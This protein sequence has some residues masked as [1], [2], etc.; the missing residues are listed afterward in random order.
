MIDTHDKETEL[1]QPMTQLAQ[2]PFDRSRIELL[3]QENKLIEALTLLRQC[4][5]AGLPERE[6]YLYM[7]LGRTRLHGPALSAT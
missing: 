7:L 6:P 4:T 2:H 5:S 3:F 1:I